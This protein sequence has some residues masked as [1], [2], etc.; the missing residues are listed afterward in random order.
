[1][2]PD[3]QP[4]H[5]QERFCLTCPGS[6]VASYRKQCGA[7]WQRKPPVA[8]RNGNR[9]WNFMT[10]S[11]W[12]QCSAHNAMPIGTGT[13]GLQP[14]IFDLLE[15]RMTSRPE[16]VAKV[17]ASRFRLRCRI[18]TD[19]AVADRVCRSQGLRTALGLRGRRT[20]AGALHDANGRGRPCRKAV[21]PRGDVCR[22][23]ARGRRV[24][25]EH[26]VRADVFDSLGRRVGFHLDGFLPSNVE[27]EL[28]IAGHDW[29][30]GI[31]RVCVRT[32]RHAHTRRFIIIR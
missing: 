1:M 21:G 11:F 26:L 8:D 32:G 2:A 12:N 3:D 18:N 17:A 22:H 24:S 20:R 29:P 30:C 6:R 27:H 23:R 13:G 4:L 9:H 10:N 28:E 16:S 14:R 15:V 5:N 19:R 7:Y 31:H 25:Q